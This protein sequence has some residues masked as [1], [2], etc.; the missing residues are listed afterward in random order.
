MIPTQYL[1]LTT[2]QC[3]VIHRSIL[4]DSS[5]ITTDYQNQ[6]VANQILQSNMPVSSL[7]IPYQ[8]NEYCSKEIHLFDRG[9]TI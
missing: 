5:I 6:V 3:R 2:N 1:V 4:K 7:I 9:V 8:M